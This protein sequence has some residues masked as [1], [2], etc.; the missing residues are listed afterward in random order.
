MVQQTQATSH[1][2]SSKKILRAKNLNVY[3]GE[4]HILRN[5][6]LHIPEGEMICLIV[7]IFQDVHSV[8]HQPFY[9]KIL[10]MTVLNSFDV[11]K[12]CLERVIF[13]LC[14]CSIF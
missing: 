11:Q 6:D 5:V 9:S 12:L 8:K 7:Y 1:P 4:S 3:Y 10:I 14:S 2:V 13:Y